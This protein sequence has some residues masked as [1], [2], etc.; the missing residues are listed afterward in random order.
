MRFSANILLMAFLLP[1]LLGYGQ[2]GSKITKQTFQYKDTLELDFYVSDQA[3][4]AD[5]P[6]LVLVHGGGFDSGKR[7]GA[8]ES[9]F[10]DAM[11]QKGYA[12]A[13]ISYRLTRKNDPFSCDCDTEKK[14]STFVGGSEDLADALVYLTADSQLLFDRNRIILIGSSAGAETVL[15]S[16]FMSHHYLFK[17]IPPINI[18]GVVSFSG[19]MVNASYISRSNAVPALF[20]H[21]KKDELVP[22]DTAAHHYCS[23]E[24][25]GYLMLDG[26]LTMTKKL[27]KLKTSYIL[28][29]H[30]EGGHEWSNK[31]FLQTELVQKFIDGMVLDQKNTGSAFKGKKIKL[32]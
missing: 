22:Y 28:A 14:M 16:A 24:K 25:A 23:E 30:P 26:P 10:C 20:I 12:V 19:A 8:D 32:R 5:R 1:P 15:H 7:D 6:L 13:S 9:K 18:S 17:H 31:A 29:F 21:G 2:Q 11:A 27:K 4:P 3:P